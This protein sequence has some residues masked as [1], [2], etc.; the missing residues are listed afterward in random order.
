MREYFF[1]FMCLSVRHFYKESKQTMSKKNTNLFF[2]IL[3]ILLSLPLLSDYIPYSEELIGSTSRISAL[4]DNFSILFAPLNN[5]AYGY[6][7]ASIQGTVFYLLPALLVK[8]GMSAFLSYKLFVIILNF[9]SLY[10]AY[11]CFRKCFEDNKEVLLA[12]VVFVCNPMRACT[13][14]TEGDL[15]Q[16]IAWTFLPVIFAGMWG[17]YAKGDT[18][19]WSYVTLGL[20]L[21]LACSVTF[22]T[23]SLIT[24]IVIALVFYKKTGLLNVLKTFCLIFA[25]GIWII[26]PIIRQLL[27]APDE[28]GLLVPYDV[29]DKGLYLVQYLRIFFKAGYEDDFM[30]NG[31]LEAKAI[32]IG[33]VL[34]CSLIGFIWIWVSGKLNEKTEKISAK[35][36]KKLFICL[37]AFMIISSNLFPWNLL[38][39]KNR[40]F[41]AFLGLMEAPYM[42]ASMVI[43]LSLPLMLAVY[44]CIE[45]EMAKNIVFVSA[46]AMA[47]LANQYYL[48]DIFFTYTPVS[49]DDLE[50][51]QG[52]TVMPMTGG[53]I[54]TAVISLIGF[55]GLLFI[56]FKNRN[57]EKNA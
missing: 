15:S 34:T 23:L 6:N 54:V 17:L 52:I 24:V 36:Y 4:A 13:L 37:I 51:V 27:Y 31:L 7:V 16:A 11:F 53:N 56:T 38:Q 25:S 9:V 22:F 57:M 12:T 42:W 5:T 50:I 20:A 10:V 26:Y 21:T 46:L 39:D 43:M 8:L 44:R 55:T 3:G 28:L 47:V 40:L 35:E 14:Y 29:R 32:G 30:E 2:I 49:K 48:N 1:S 19:A 18:K 45:N 33:T 41:S